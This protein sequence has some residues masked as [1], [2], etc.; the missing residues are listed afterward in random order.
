[1]SRTTW[2]NAICLFF[3]LACVPAIFADEKDEWKALK[4][5]WNVE[6][7][8]LNGGDMTEAFKSA[9]LMMEEGKYTVT[10]LGNSDKG[11]LKLDLAAKPK[12]IS[13]SGTEGPN[14]DKTYEG[15]YE[16]DGDTL[17]V[18]YALEGKDPP[19][20][21]ESK[22]GTQTLFVVYKREKDK[23]KDKEK[24]KDKDK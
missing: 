16:I 9:V 12:R 19:K 10:F 6:K 24:D 22:E 20:A 13:I 8:V 1:M 23:P 2:R 21:F 15:I 17:K 4:G 7:A 18:C 11:T 14:K 3:A 5:T